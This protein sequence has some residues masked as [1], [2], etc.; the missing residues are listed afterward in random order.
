VRLRKRVSGDVDD[1]SE[2]DAE[3]LLSTLPHL[4]ER[5]DDEPSVTKE[6]SAASKSGARHKR[7]DLRAEE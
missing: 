1:Y 3:R 4:Y 5:A 7:K 2:E 6:S